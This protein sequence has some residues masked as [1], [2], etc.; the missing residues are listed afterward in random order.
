MKGWK[1]RSVL[2]GLLALVFLLAGVQVAAAEPAVSGCGDAEFSFEV[3]DAADL[4]SIECSTADYKN[5]PSLHFKVAVKNTSDTPQR[6]RVNIFTDSGKAV[7]GLL[8]RKTKAG[9]IEPGQSGEF[10]YPIKGYA[11]TPEKVDVLIKTISTQ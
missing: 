10:T 8:P 5:V 1:N 7:G 6:Y 2:T 4:V 3:A 9:L 11:E